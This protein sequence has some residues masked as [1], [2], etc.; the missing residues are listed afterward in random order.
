MRKFNLTRE[1]QVRLNAY[2]KEDRQWKRQ[3]RVTFAQLMLKFAWAKDDKANI[4]FYRAVVDANE[5]AEDQINFRK[6]IRKNPDL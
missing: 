3:H 5:L 1:Q 6:A 2:L 4:E